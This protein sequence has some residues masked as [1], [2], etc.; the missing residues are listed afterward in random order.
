MDDARDRMR[1]T[2]QSAALLIRHPFP[3][4]ATTARPH[5]N[6]GSMRIARHKSGGIFK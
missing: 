3:T 4:S 6:R 2:E 5:S 1:L